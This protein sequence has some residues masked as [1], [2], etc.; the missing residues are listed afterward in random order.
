MRYKA[1]K[2]HYEFEDADFENGRLIKREGIPKRMADIVEIFGA[3]NVQIG[4]PQDLN[5]YRECV[6]TAHAASC[7]V[8]LYD[9]GESYDIDALT[10]EEF[11]AMRSLLQYWLELLEKKE[12]AEAP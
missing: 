8:L 10:E 6:V 1:E 3:D 5:R 12:G 11:T 9:R 2:G 4:L 7:N